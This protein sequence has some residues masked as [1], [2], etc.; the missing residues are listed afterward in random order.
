[1]SLDARVAVVTGA[2]RGLG[3]AIAVE[4]ARRGAI[5]WACY[6]TREAEV[7]EAAREAGVA[8]T[9]HALDVRDEASV[10][11]LF[12]A[13]RSTHGACDILVNNAGIARDEL[14]AMSSRE[15][16]DEVL[17]VNV[18][19]AASCARAAARL[20]IARKRGAIVNV[21]SIAGQRSSVGQASYAASKGALLALTRTLAAELGPKGLRVNAV[22]PG[23]IDAGMLARVDARAVAS[24]REHIPLG[25]LGRA[26]E[27]AKV[28]AFLAS[29]DAS[30][31]SGQ[32]LAIDGGLT[33]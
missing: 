5:V 25:R 8:L 18:A 12:D 6:R 16:W 31:V 20:M 21:A 1:M 10:R 28:V 14:F 32:A 19:G 3:R 2:S 33:A 23:L 24:K 11:A 9:A 27:V 22:V 17:A 15:A 30:Y 13:V 26:E 4:L 29:D 7:H